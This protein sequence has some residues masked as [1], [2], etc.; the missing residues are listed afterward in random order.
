MKG[1][2]EILL[3]QFCDNEESEVR[4]SLLFTGHCVLGCF[5]L[6]VSESVVE[7]SFK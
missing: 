1:A 2:L 3:L 7:T 6:Q 5:W 4:G